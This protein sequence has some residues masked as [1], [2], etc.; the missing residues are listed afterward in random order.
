[1]VIVRTHDPEL[2][3]KCA[4]RIVH[5]RCLDASLAEERPRA[6]FLIRVRIL[7]LFDFSP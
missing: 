6:E 3:A 7:S 2:V 4:D 1:M 5:L